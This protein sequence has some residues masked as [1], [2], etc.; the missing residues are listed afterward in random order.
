MNSSEF[1]PGYKTVYKK[2]QSSLPVF[3]VQRTVHR[4]IFL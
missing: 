1:T 4:G 2:K 3:D